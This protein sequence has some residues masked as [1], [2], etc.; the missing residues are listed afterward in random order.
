MPYKTLRES[1]RLEKV[2]LMPTLEELRAQL[3]ANPKQE[4]P[5]S[6]RVAAVNSLLA[7]GL[8]SATSNSL[9]TG[10]ADWKPAD[11]IEKPPMEGR[12]VTY[13][14]DDAKECVILRFNQELPRGTETLMV[15]IPLKCFSNIPT[16]SS[17][18]Q[19]ALDQKRG[20]KRAVINNI[21][22]SLQMQIDSARRKMA[23]ADS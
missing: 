1:E 7:S 12:F 15:N 11:R 6:K 20:W 9:P 18:V 23:D 16:F 13:K 19:K 10:M 3:R 4:T 14:L 22:R 5:K 17:E 8:I 2:L 21:Y